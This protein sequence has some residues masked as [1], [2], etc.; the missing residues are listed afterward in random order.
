MV[1]IVMRVYNNANDWRQ[2]IDCGLARICPHTEVI[3]VNHGSDDV[4]RA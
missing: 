1:A 4:G 3:V 2:V